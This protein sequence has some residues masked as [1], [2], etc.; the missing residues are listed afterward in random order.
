MAQPG[1]GTSL[2]E[3]AASM[4]KLIFGNGRFAAQLVLPQMSKLIFGGAG[5]LR[6]ALRMGC[7]DCCNKLY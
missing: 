6:S 5:L 1:T 2:R 3:G 4:S 7:A